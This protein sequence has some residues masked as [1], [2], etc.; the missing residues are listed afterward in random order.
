MSML[1]FLADNVFRFR[2]RDP[3]KR[4]ANGI[5]TW[6]VD[7]YEEEMKKVNRDFFLMGFVIGS[8]LEAIVAGALW[9]TVR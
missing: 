1:L 5:H 8:I 2:Y 4:D 6:D 7:V 3:A 9:L